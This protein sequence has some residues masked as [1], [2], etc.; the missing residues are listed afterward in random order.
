MPEIIRMKCIDQLSDAELKGKRVVLRVDFN[1]PLDKHGNVADMFRVKQAW[2]TVEYLS[3]RGARVIAMSHIGKDE[4]E[5]L[6][7]VARAIN[8]FAKIIFIPDISGPV[9][10]D[11]V[12]AMRDGDIILLENLRRDPGE[13]TNEEAFAKKLAALGEIYVDDAFAAAHR[14]HASIVGVAKFL[15]AYAGFL[16]RDEV[17]NLNAA[18]NPERPSFA[19]LG[20]AKFETKAPLIS[21]LLATYDHLFIV[22]ALA[23]DIFKARGL[24]VG[25]SLVSKEVP[26]LDVL[27]HANL[28]VPTDVTVEGTDGQSRTKKPE[29]VDVNEK[30]MDIG[31]DSVANIAP[32]IANAK[33]ILW[34]GTTGY[35]EGGYISWMKAIGELVGKSSAQKVIGGG[36]TIAALEAT[37]IDQSKLGFLSTGG[38]AMLEFMMKGTLPGIEVLK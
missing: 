36:D 17:K 2:K 3:Q 9:A 7:P 31:P 35:Y 30:I 33:F 37:G 8:A 26:G 11:A 15:P 18:L 6:E 19:I 25:K 38:G 22:G 32:F 20:G 1:L 10:Q 5:S 12:R 29:E 14:E 13:K 21:K 28:I 4:K 23:N 24:P 16:I 34:N 27:E